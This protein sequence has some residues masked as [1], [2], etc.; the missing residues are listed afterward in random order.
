M[1]VRMS[2][3]LAIL[4]ILLDFAGGGYHVPT[5][6]G[7]NILDIVAVGAAGFVMVT[8]QQA[9]RRLATVAP[10][11]AWV[12]F[13]YAV[14][15]L[16]AENQSD[17]IAK[18]VQVTLRYSLIAI[19]IAV[20]V[21][22]PYQLRWLA[23]GMCLAACLNSIICMLEVH[24]NALIFAINGHVADSTLRNY[25]HDLRPSG[26][27]ANPN[28]AAF[29][30]VL[31]YIFARWTPLPI[32][33]TTRIMILLGIVVSN[34]RTATLVFPL[35]MAILA[36]TDRTQ[37]L[38]NQQKRR[39]A[40]LTALGLMLLIVGGI[41]VSTWST[42]ATFRDDM[43]RRWA[44]L[45]HQEENSRYPTR[46]RAVVIMFERVME[47][48][49]VG[50]GAF[51]MHWD[52]SGKMGGVGVHNEYI[53]IWG[54]GGLISLLTFGLLLLHGLQKSWRLPRG[55]D[56]SVMMLTWVVWL[57][58]QMTWHNGFDDANA[59]II[60]ALLWVVPAVIGEAAKATAV[61]NAP[62]RPRNLGY[63]VPAMRPSRGPQ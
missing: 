49:I 62:A 63:P 27:W 11:V 29:W 42:S 38:G 2:H 14:G 4:C 15:F 47:N 6:F 36:L 37:S 43:E 55:P 50:Y 45:T 34:S 39:L 60:W 24:N 19:C 3:F 5:R 9:S 54:E 13:F 20:A 61:P 52:A 28:A 48:P 26:L 22:R 12:I 51:S 16:V 56:R 8:D 30:F 35:V 57:V 17:Y 31:T 46:Q 10:L 23:I 58:I 53:C 44:R 41:A 33:W 18:I 40:T 21:G 7:F 1:L 25:M 32:R 59:A